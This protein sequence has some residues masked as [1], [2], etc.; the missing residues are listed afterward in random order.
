[1]PRRGL[2]RAGLT[3][4]HSKKVRPFA[5]L[6]VYISE[7]GQL[8]VVENQSLQ[9]R[10]NMPSHANETLDIQ[11]LYLDNESC[12]RCLQTEGNLDVAATIVRGVMEL[13][14]I[15][16]RIER[17]LVEDR[18]LAHEVQLRTSPTIRINGSDIGGEL[19]QNACS[20]CSNL[21]SQPICC[22]TWKWRGRTTNYAPIGLIVEEMLKALF[23]QGESASAV[24]EGFQLPD[25]LE[26]FFADAESIDGSPCQ[27][28]SSCC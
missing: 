23:A 2:T 13:L 15:E 14:G 5:H 9:T 25:N 27:S 11:L 20:D 18:Q 10:L 21:A 16:L 22:R 7:N 26:R 17:V 3:A 6:L 1:M 28:T 4:G 24:A 8:P 19:E 12:S